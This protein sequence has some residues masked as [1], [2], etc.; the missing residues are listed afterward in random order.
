MLNSKGRLVLM[1]MCDKSKEKK[2]HV[3]RA[4]YF[5]DIK[6]YNENVQAQLGNNRF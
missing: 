5:K 4:K 2:Y 6:E 3:E 1:D